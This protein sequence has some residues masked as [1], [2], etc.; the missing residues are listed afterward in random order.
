[1]GP[2][3]EPCGT[4]QERRKIAYIDRETSITEV[5]YEP[6]Q[7]SATDTNTALETKILWFT[8]SKAV[9]RSRRIRTAQSPESIGRSRSLDTFSKAD[10]CAM[11]SPKT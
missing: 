4:P 8:V 6:G 2:R 11:V 5:G 7:G 1:M 10:S 9:L 3:M